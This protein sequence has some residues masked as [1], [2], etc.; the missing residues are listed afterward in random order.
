MVDGGCHQEHG[1]PYM[2]TI[3]ALIAIAGIASVCAVANG[4]TFNF[5]NNIPLAVPDAPAPAVTTTTAPIVG[6]GVITT[7]ACTLE[8][9]PG[10]TWTGDLVVQLTFTPTDGSAAVMVDLTNRRGGSSDWIGTYQFIDTA[11]TIF[12]A[13]NVVGPPGDYQATTVGGAAVVLNTAFASK[14]VAGV[15]TI[16]A[17]DFAGA[18]I[19]TIN[20]AFVTVVGGSASIPPSGASSATAIVRNSASPGPASGLFAVRTTGGYNPVSTVAGVRANLTSILGSGH[21]SDQLFDNGTNGDVVAGDGVFSRTVTAPITLADG[22]YSIPFVVSD[23]RVPPRTGTGAGTINVTT[24]TPPVSTALGTISANAT[25]TGTADA[26]VGEAAWFSFTS[27][28]AATDPGSYLDTY[29]LSNSGYA[30]TY[31]AIFDA[32]GAFLRSNDDDG[33]GLF[34]QL[35]FGRTT[36][37]RVYNGGNNAIGNDGPLPAGTYYVAIVRYFSTF[38]S[39]FGFSNAATSATTAEIGVTTSNGA[40]A[41]INPTMTARFAPAVYSNST[42]GPAGPV[43]FTSSLLS[44]TVVS[45]RFP[46]AITNTVT[47]D[48]TDGLGGGTSVTLF[49]NGTNGDLIAGDNIFS[50]TVNLTAV[51]VGAH[52][53]TISLV[54]DQGRTASASPVLTRGEDLV[55]TT[56]NLGTLSFTGTPAVATGSTALVG[57]EV[58]WLRFTLDAA[59]DIGGT[60]FLDIDTNG[61]TIDTHIGLFD[62]VGTYLG[63]SDDDSGAGLQSALTFGSID[64][65]GR[66]TN[67]AGGPNNGSDGGLAAGTYYLALNFWPATYN[68][69]FIATST[70]GGLGG[71]YVYN[72]YS[73][74][75]NGSTGPV[76]IADINGDQIIDGADFILFINSFGVGDVSIDANADVAGGIPSGGDGI[77]DGTDFIAFINAF[78]AGC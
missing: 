41:S 21:T 10:H 64:P 23:N 57:R 51:A 37:E 68:T 28:T 36:P 73:G 78:G 19:G 4:Q 76:C 6:A 9:N 11:P 34:S 50:R 16:T 62:S 12:A 8:W 25:V 69:P 44:A 66:D 32:A 75:Q 56:T 59:V 40:P 65:T 3:A 27:A 22:S 58:N 71:T 39:P 55:L 13:G 47:A 49:D 45:G 61:S 52:T 30:D 29:V 35:S 72:V 31:M 67:P 48:L 1:T 20:S 14:P 54:D 5:V 74:D 18:D 33:A 42:G 53:A 38:S 17:Q 63:I 70:S 43:V 60:R 46:P 26:N 7:V 77:I 2:K 24:V 15:W